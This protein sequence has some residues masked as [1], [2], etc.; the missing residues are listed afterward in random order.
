MVAKEASNNSRARV[1]LAMEAVV[2]AAPAPAP[3]A[4]SR[5]AAT[6]TTTKAMVS[7]LAMVADKVATPIRRIAATRVTNKGMEVALRATT[8]PS[9]KRRQARAM[10]SSSPSTEAGLRPTVVASLIREVSRSLE[11]ELQITGTTCHREMSISLNNLKR[12]LPS[13]RTRLILDQQ[14]LPRRPIPSLAWALLKVSVSSPMLASLHSRLHLV[15]LPPLITTRGRVVPGM[16][17]QLYQLGE[18][19]AKVQAS[20]RS[21]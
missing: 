15:L 13:A 9:T 3:V 5:S 12:H 6:T 7:L 18:V 10:L 20:S 16:V 14:L 11:E 4:S 2:V 17:Q 8:T 21:A 1:A 19:D